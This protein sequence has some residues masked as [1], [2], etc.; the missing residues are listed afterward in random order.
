[1]INFKGHALHPQMCQ[2]FEFCRSCFSV[3]LLIHTSLGHFKL[4]TAETAGIGLCR[5]V[6]TRT[7]PERA[8]HKIKPMRF[9]LKAVK[10]IIKKKK[11]NDLDSTWLAFGFG[12]FAQSCL[13]LRLKVDL[14]CNPCTNRQSQWWFRPGNFAEIELTMKASVY[15]SFLD[16]NV[17]LRLR[18]LKL[19]PNYVMQQDNDPTHSSKSVTKRKWIKALQWPSKKKKKKM[20]WRDLEKAV[21]KQMPPNLNELKQR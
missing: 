20:L 18:Q 13:L 12:M 6:V 16:S 2:T 8:S 3:V 11:L 7:K 19:A 4:H 10:I 17:P 9:F 15:Q 5:H 14:L 1:M 21:H